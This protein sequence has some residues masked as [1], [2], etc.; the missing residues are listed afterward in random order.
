MMRKRG[1]DQRARL[2][3]ID[4]LHQLHRSF[5]IGEQGGDGFAL[6][7]GQRRRVDSGAFDQSR[8]PQ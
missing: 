3:R 2:F 6:A 7:L 1:I 8:R 4:I 5:D